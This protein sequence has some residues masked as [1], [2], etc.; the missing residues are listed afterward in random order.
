MSV[1][2]ANFDGRTP[3]HL[4]CDQG[5]L[6]IVK[7]LVSSCNAEADVE[8]RWGRTPLLC[9]EL[10]NFNEVCLEILALFICQSFYL[11]L[12]HTQ[13]V[14]FLQAPQKQQFHSKA[15][16]FA[17]APSWNSPRSRGLLL[18]DYFHPY[19]KRHLWLQSILGHQNRFSCAAAFFHSRIIL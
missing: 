16:S 13:I 7:Y 17:G 14:S 1:N 11:S 10:G 5:H 15:A 3:L 8:D 6:G 2:E 4:A 9:A 19:L 12:M 18:F